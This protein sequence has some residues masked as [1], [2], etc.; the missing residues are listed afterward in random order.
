MSD[1]FNNEISNLIKSNED[2][3]LSFTRQYLKKFYKDIF[4]KQQGVT[5]SSKNGP[6]FLKGLIGSDR[7]IGEKDGVKYKIC[8]PEFSTDVFDHVSF[9]NKDGKPYFITYQ[10]YHIRNDGMEKLQEFCN[11][12]DLR[13]DIVPMSPHCPLASNMIL[14]SRKS[15][16]ETNFWIG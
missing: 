15:D 10:P 6:S 1:E 7:Y 5:P 11:E 13:F 4:M 9:W 3:F 14:I 12:C 8:L 16:P 2:K